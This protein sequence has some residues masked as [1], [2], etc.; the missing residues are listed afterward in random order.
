MKPAPSALRGAYRPGSG[1]TAAAYR[2]HHKVVSPVAPLRAKVPSSSFAP[3]PA[4]LALSGRRAHR[5]SRQ[6]AALGSLRACSSADGPPA[7]WETLLAEL[8]VAS[9]GSPQ[10]LMDA[11]L[12]RR[13]EVTTGFIFWA[14]HPLP[15]P[16]ADSPAAVFVG[17]W[18][19][20]ID[21][22]G[23]TVGQDY[24]L[25]SG[26]R[27]GDRGREAR[28]RGRGRR[29][30]HALRAARRPLRQARP[31][32]QHS[33]FSPRRVS[34]SPA[35]D[36]LSGVDSDADPSVSAD[37]SPLDRADTLPSVSALSLSTAAAS[38]VR[39]RCRRSLSPFPH[40]TALHRTARRVAAHPIR[41]L[42]HG[43]NA[44][45][46]RRPPPPP[47]THPPPTTTT[48]MTAARAP[49]APSA[50]RSSP[51]PPPP[52][53][54]AW[55]GCWARGGPRWRCKERRR[56]T[57]CRRVRRGR[58]PPVARD[59]HAQRAGGLARLAQLSR[60]TTDRI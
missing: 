28:R 46:L 54:K 21:G 23:L 38:L 50:V 47:P 48:T 16:C 2:R 1:P 18:T 14:R 53:G 17:S 22:A 55:Q 7:Q 10:K 24:F 8:R 35:T 11:V 45:A 49:P 3:S 39:A 31:R 4:R 9:L 25:L 13:A 52:P 43:A 30:G 36:L 27:Q 6:T 37:A 58:S 59:R 33:R 57:D 51:R 26:W 56:R 20:R 60:S 15:A 41:R 40:H 34:L 32:T 44:R 19:M 29:A 12:S 42:T 5:R